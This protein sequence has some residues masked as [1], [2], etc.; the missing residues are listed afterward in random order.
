MSSGNTHREL[1]AVK[2][3]RKMAGM[4]QFLIENS[5]KYFNTTIPTIYIHSSDFLHPS[6]TDIFTN[7]TFTFFF[8]NVRKKANAMQIDCQIYLISEHS[9]K[10]TKL[11]SDKHVIYVFFFFFKKELTS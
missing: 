7:L 10:E 11:H 5:R 6:V 2:A 3:P 4:L 9:H 8:I 1:C